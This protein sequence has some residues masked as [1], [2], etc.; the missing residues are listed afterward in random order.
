MS[1]PFSQVLARHRK[2]IS[3]GDVK[4]KNRITTLDVDARSIAR[5]IDG[6]H[7]ARRAGLA[8][9][10]SPGDVM[11]RPTCWLC[12]TCLTAF[13]GCSED[14]ARRTRE[15]IASG[16]EFV[17]AGKYGEAS[18]EY[19]NAIKTTPTSA[20]AHE[21]LADA[22]GRAHDS[23]TAARA[24]LRVAELKPDDSG[25]QIRAASLYLLAGRYEDARDRA[26]AAVDAD[27]GDANAQLVL[28]QA[29]AGLHDAASSEAA[30]REAVRLAPDAPEPH[31][32]LGSHHWSAGRIPDAEAELRKAVAAGPQHVVAN[33][34]LALLLMATGRSGDAEPLWRVVAAGPEGFP[35]AWP[36][37]L[38]T[39]NRLGEAESALADLGARDATRDAARVRLAAVQYAQN[40]RDAAHGTLRTVLDGTPKN[41][42]A[43]L[44]QARFF[45]LEQR[46]DDA[47]RAVQ[48]AALADPT[49]AQAALAEGEVYAA[50]GDEG[51]AVRAF[52]TA[53][54]L[55]PRD[56]MPYLRMAR[57]RMRHGRAVEAVEAAERARTIWPDDLAPRLVLI[58][59]L[60]ASGRRARAIEQTQSAIGRW[61]KLAELHVQLGVLQAADGQHEPARRS[62]STALQLDPASIAA[63]S[64]LADLDVRGGRAHAA[65]GRLDTR[66]RQQ[67]NNPALLLLSARIHAAAGQPDKAEATLRKLVRQDPSNLDAFATLGRF[68][69]AT[70]RL[71]DARDQFQ[72]LAPEDKS[73]G[74][75]TMVGMILQAQNRPDEAQR[76]FE[77]ALETNSRA[78]VAANNLAW[79]HHEQGRLDAALRW[80]IVANE[81]LRGMPEAKDTLGWIHVRRGEYA[82]G[83]PMLAAAVES[84]PDSPVYRYH[85]GFAYWKTGS[86]SRARE[87]LGRALAS[88]A[89]FAGRDEAARILGELDTDA[90]NAS[91]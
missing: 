20:E 43:L 36:D 91:R 4:Q 29:L 16:D 70:G 14:P 85:L 27:H 7:R 45:Q 52:E 53:L 80:A 44:L 87:E 78:G 13:F 73:A 77:R 67:P 65:L 50:L 32:A 84:R 22:A 23:Q 46:W 35:F 26:T 9:K 17:R 1:R 83:L 40:E 30:L 6:L 69:L 64:A 72:R 42:P 82:S 61:P 59:A 37:Y 55:N 49:H 75:G 41:V 38:V 62:L 15:Y 63:L 21:K 28:A 12:A 68:Y 57:V 34:A 66:L 79:L 86:L 81:Q 11:F 74:A 10:A 71:D 19:R 89:A 56:A 54:K 39:M 2:G 60:A 88:D 18:I 5:R 47:L 58:E 76:A 3:D 33:R 31:V 24:I 51:R 8:Q 90:P 25:A 48:A